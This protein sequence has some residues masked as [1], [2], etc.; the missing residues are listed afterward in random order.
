MGEPLLELE[1]VEKRFAS[2]EGGALVV[3]RGVSLRIAAGESA[4][5]VGPSG[6]GKSTLLNLAGTLDRPSAGRVRIAGRDVSSLSDAALAEVRRR[7]VGFVFQ[8][9]HLLP[10]C[11]AL[12]N[13][14]VPLLADA[15]GVAPDGEA[16]GR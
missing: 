12:E 10:Q 9:H 2:P 11:T 16:R 5:I 14:L 7:D 4:A 3:L 8:Q 13:V 1:G 15:A 6:S